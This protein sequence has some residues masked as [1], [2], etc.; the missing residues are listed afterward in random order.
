[1]PS[2]QQEIRYLLS[3]VYN[4]WKKLPECE[5]Q[6]TSILRADPDNATANNDLGYI[7]ADHNKNLDEA[8][9]MIR[10]ALDL[11]RE[12]RKRAGL[13]VEDNAAY[14]DS[15]GWVLFRRGKIEDAL[16]ELERAA[17]LPEGDDPVIWDHLGDVY[18][19]LM[20]MDEA[21]T[22]WR[23]AV[24]LYDQNR[25]KKSDEKYRELQRKLER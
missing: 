21:R 12:Q 9:A 6:L 1:L 17:K 7:W 22:A 10:K 24:E 16:R 25:R 13:D 19:H 4:A 2:D 3:N 15:L 20:R 11:D 14:V 5:Q 23:R 18:R 8:E